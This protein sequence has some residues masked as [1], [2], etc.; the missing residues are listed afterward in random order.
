MNKINLGKVRIT[1]KGEWTTIAGPFEALDA[2]LYNGSTYLAK[3]D[4]PVGSEP[5]LNDNIYWMLMAKKGDVGDKGEQG[6]QGIQGLKGDQ[7]VQGDQG[8]QGPQ[9]FSLLQGSGFPSSSLG[10][11]GDTYVNIDSGSLYE[12]SDNSWQQT[13]SLKGPQGIQ[14]IKGDTGSQG[15]KGDKGDTG[16][17]GIQGEQGVKGDKGDS[18][19]VA[20]QEQLDELDT[21]LTVVEPAVSFV[22]QLDRWNIA[23][24]KC[25]WSAQSWSDV[26]AEMSKLEPD[27]LYPDNVFMTIDVSGAGNPQLVNSYPGLLPP[28]RSGDTLTMPASNCAIMLSQGWTDMAE[29]WFSGIYDA[30]PVAIGRTLAYIRSKR[31]HNNAVAMLANGTIVCTSNNPRD[32]AWSGGKLEADWLAEPIEIPEN[33]TELTGDGYT[34]N[35][36]TQG[37][38]GGEMPANSQV[39]ATDGRLLTVVADSG[40]NLPT[41]AVIDGQTAALAGVQLASAF[42]SIG[43]V[44]KLYVSNSNMSI[45]RAEYRAVTQATYSTI[46]CSGFPVVGVA[47]AC[48]IGSYASKNSFNIRANNGS[49]PF[50][51][52]IPEA[53]CTVINSWDF[54]D[55]FIEINGNR[56][57]AA[58][59]MSA[60]RLTGSIWLGSEN[61]AKASYISLISFN[62]NHIGGSFKLSPTLASNHDMWDSVAKTWRDNAGS[63]RLGKLQIPP[64][65]DD[66]N[67]DVNGFVLNKERIDDRNKFNRLDRQI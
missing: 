66:P 45:G 18:G 34:I 35:L 61:I 8:I 31:W 22:D 10:V 24:S 63:G 51:A 5:S 3:R 30:V 6:I 43:S 7:G 26:V 47:L 58:T 27:L 65:A 15:P 12:K 64:S 2:V 52:V 55:K 40:G 4:V 33:S 42:F 25:F 50:D 46:W 57:S 1:L 36:R 19:D 49:R 48:G 28:T 23:L 44:I 53:N 39:Y 21:R 11:N 41:C 67:K 56:A 32:L 60:T 13:G 62:F 14:G 9:G 16:P 29:F 59:S 17:Q 20:A 54:N 37:L 38:I